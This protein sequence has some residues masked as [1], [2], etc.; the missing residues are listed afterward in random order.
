MAPEGTFTDL[1]Q[2]PRVQMRTPFPCAFSHPG[3]RSS[4]KG[5][6]DGLGVVFDIS[7][8]GAKVM[9]QK[10]PLSGDQ[11]AITFRFPCQTSSTKID[12]A[13]VRWSGTHE[14]GLEFTAL[15]EFAGMRLHKFM[16]QA[17][18]DRTEMM[19]VLAQLV[20]VD[21]GRAIFGFEYL[22]RKK[23]NYSLDSLRHVDE[24]L[25]QIR[26]NNGIEEA[27]SDVVARVGAYLGEVIRRN[28]T[29]HAWYWIDYESAKSLDPKVCEALGAV[30]GTTAVLFSGN[31][32]FAFPLMQVER[33]LRQACG[34]DLLSFAETMLSW[35]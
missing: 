35:K 24:F 25:G 4:W 15:S 28:A 19:R 34:D 11:I 27:W 1:R 6:R 32:E 2:Y 3:G 30:I 16:T 13:R 23:L 31:R 17:L 5:N 12:V 8:R 20:P 18:N 21:K 33:R 14:F 26:Q 29:N 10:V 22:D 9:S 7:R